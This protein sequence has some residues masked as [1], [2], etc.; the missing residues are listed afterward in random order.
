LSKPHRLTKRQKNQNTTFDQRNHLQLIDIIPLT[1][2]QRKTFNAFRAGKNLF[3]HGVAGTG[4]TFVSIYLSMK[5]LEAQRYDRLIIYRSTVASRDMGFLPGNVRDKT[6]VYEA[7]YQGVFQRL[8]NR[9]DA[10]DLLKQ[11]RLVEFESTAYVRGITI[12]NAIVII[13]EAQN[14]HWMEIYS[15]MTRLGNNCRVLICGDY[16]QTDL[17]KEQSGITRLSNVISKIDMFEAIEFGIDD[18]VRSPLVK[19]FIIACYEESV[20]P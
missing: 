15:I 12:E 11:K 16:R 17:V 9:G 2:N 7:P 10:Y 1:P 4:K 6:R 18:I 20:Y 19:K 8:Y 14:L 3:L 5:E 13:D